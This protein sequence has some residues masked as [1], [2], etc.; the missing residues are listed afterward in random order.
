MIV[1][2]ATFPGDQELAFKNVQWW[3]ELGGCRGHEILFIHDS[4]CYSGTVDA[5]GIELSKAFDKVHPFI[6]HTP[7][8][9]WPEGANYFFRAATNWM[10][11]TQWPSFMW[12]EPDA[13]PIKRGWLDVIVAEYKSC[14]KKFLG[15]R[16]E[17]TVAGR[18]VPLHMSGVGIYPNPLHAYA[19]EAYRAHEIAWDM[20]GKDQIVPQAHFTKLIEH[21][22]KHP[23]FRSLSEV[24]T[25][26]RPECMLFHSSK[27]GSLI[28]LLRKQQNPAVPVLADKAVETNQVSGGEVRES[29]GADR[30]VTQYEISRGGR[31][32][33]TD[34]FIRT[35]PGDYPWLEYS[36][37]SM[38][39]F[40]T[41]FRKVWVVSPAP[42]P[43]FI[44]QEP[45]DNNINWKVLADET[46]DGYLAQQISKLYADFLTQNEPDYIMH[47]DSDVIF[48]TPCTPRTFF[49]GNKLAW[50]YTP[51]S[52]IETPWQPI[53]EKFMGFPQPF[54]FMRRFPMLMPRWIYPKLREFCHRIHGR[55]MSDYVAAQPLRE[56]SEFN[57]L[58]CYAYFHH[59]DDFVWINTIAPEPFVIPNPVAKQFHSWGGITPEVQTEIDTLLRG[60][61]KADSKPSDSGPHFIP[62]VENSAPSQLATLQD[63]YKLGEWLNS[64]GLDGFGVEIGVHLGIF[65]ESILSQWKGQALFLVDPWKDW[66][67]EEYWD[68]T[69]TQNWPLCYEATMERVAK[70]P[71]RTVVMRMT[72]DEAALK[73]PPSFF[74]FVYIDG[75]HHLPQVRRDIEN[76]WPL[77]K[78]GGLFC[79]HDYLDAD[80][81]VWKCDV[82]KEVDAFAERMGL[83]LHNIG[84]N[85]W[86]ILKPISSE[87]SQESKGNGDLSR[88]APEPPPVRPLFDMHNAVCYLKE[89]AETSTNH[90]MRLMVTLAKNDLTPRWPKRKRRKK[91]QRETT[92]PNDTP[93]AEAHTPAS[94]RRKTSQRTG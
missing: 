88:C 35:Y 3:N 41:G 64:A 30:R 81:E 10:E 46:P 86:F 38:I 63:R 15:D 47:V 7:M 78:P 22:W 16:V 91:Q 12:M 70:Y 56:F 74:S 76:W 72:S 75:N 80:N 62:P 28:D 5:I 82:K 92:V 85:G 50:Y 65:S 9:G 66:T 61:E 55:V 23:S 25:Q 6:A 73:F 59:K 36:L 14:G 2:L 58:G 34:I 13:I 94:R 69:R 71:G 45:F 68:A 54:E 42:P 44:A 93:K 27:D 24:A 89:F 20:A 83:P 84:D 53:M 57:A 21:A 51:Y 48:H 33:I 31:E 79:G 17:V 39:K 18:E 1:V 4:R 90:R 43:P 29:T 60:A 8:D 37:H 67:Q 87:V 40:C 32:P 19:G 77:L 11:R 49:W 52:E 26:I